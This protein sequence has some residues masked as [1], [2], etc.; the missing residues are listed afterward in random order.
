M[1]A[2]GAVMT[3]GSAGSSSRRRNS[4]VPGSTR[5][6]GAR[7]AMGPAHAD[8]ASD[9]GAA[10][11]PGGGCSGSRR[12]ASTPGAPAVQAQGMRTSAT[13]GNYRISAVRKLLVVVV[14]AHDSFRPMV[15][16]NGTRRAYLQ[17]RLGVLLPPRLHLITRVSCPDHKPCL[18][19]CLPSAPATQEGSV[20]NTFAS[21]ASLQSFA[22]VAGDANY[23]HF[24]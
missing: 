18:P 8:R 22:D 7:Q 13:G 10:V 14:T 15:H 16:S 2:A 4:S 5:D 3:V 17:I 6:P 1:T 9:T 19:A 11:G 23:S 20:T 21:T 12:G 24:F